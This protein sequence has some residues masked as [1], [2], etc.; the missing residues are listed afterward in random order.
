MQKQINNVSFLIVKV[1]SHS[2]RDFRRTEVNP[3]KVQGEPLQSWKRP[4]W[5]KRHPEKLPVPCKLTFQKP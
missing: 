4:F 5:R 1:P 2:R 3:L